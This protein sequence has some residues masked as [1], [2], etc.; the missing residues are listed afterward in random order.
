MEKLQKAKTDVAAMYRTDPNINRVKGWTGT[1]C[2]RLPSAT[3]EYLAEKLPVVQWLPHY[4]YRWIVQDVI[5]GITVGV[6][7]IPQGLAYAKIATIPVEQGLYASWLPSALYFLLGTSKDLSVGPASVLALLTAEAVAELQKEGYEAAQISAAMAFLVGLLALVVGLLKLGFLL[8]FVSGPVLTGWISAVALIIGLGQVGSLV[9]L[10]TGSG[11]ARIVRDVLGHL[12]QIQPLTLAVGFTSIAALYALELTGKRWGKKSAVLKF[13][14][15][16]RAVLVL[17]VAT[18]VSY[19]VNRGFRGSDEYKWEVTEVRTNG[20]PAPR[21]HDMELLRR[22][23]ARCLAPF[24]AMS[25]EHLGVGK[26]FGLRNNY[27]IDKSQELFY[28]GVENMANSFFSSLTTGAAMSRTA[29]NSD[30]GVRSPLGALFTAGWIILTL[31]KFSPILFWIPKAT[32]SAIIIMAIVHLISSPRVFY[33]YWRMSFMDFVAAMLGFWVTLFTSTEL[34]LAAAVGFNIAYTLLRLAFPRWAGLSHEDSSHE[35]SS[36]E[37]KD[38]TPQHPTAHV[39]IPADAY[40]VR[41]TDDILFPNAE[42]VKSAIIESV[43]VHFEPE[44][45]V[46][47]TAQA[48]DKDRSW[49]GSAA[50]RIGRIRKRKGIVPRHGDVMPLRYVV[51]D[52]GM[53]AFIDVTGVQ[54]L[55]ELKTELRR[56]Y[57]KGP[58]FRFVNMVDPVRERF[59]RSEWRFANAGEAAKE[60]DVVYPSLTAALLDHHGSYNLGLAQE[61]A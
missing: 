53:V 5:A 49:N 6:V 57:G 46:S 50:K 8:D 25:V 58:E 40:L 13:V 43:K 19:L 26:A 61:K 28:L 4:D 14:C 12:N 45:D 39:Y 34:G 54:S 24:I 1:V 42:R 33:R 47:P 30:C 55:M 35:N 56:Y 48:K 29:V 37:S 32:L 38:Y 36:H 44:S 23:F 7:L 3:A 11:T 31:Y 60:S 2:R 52:F 17:A 59:L 41:F 16:S 18:L 10:E 15:P 20:L 9:G 22:V 51:L 27:S 21:G